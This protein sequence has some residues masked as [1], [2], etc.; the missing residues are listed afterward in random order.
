MKITPRTSFT[1]NIKCQVDGFEGFL[2]ACEFSYS[3]LSGVLA[4][5]SSSYLTLNNVCN[6]SERRAERCDFYFLGIQ[7]VGGPAVYR[8]LTRHDGQDC[9]VCLESTGCFLTLRP[10]AGH[11][12]TYW[13]IRFNGVMNDPT[14]PGKYPGMTL[15]RYSGDEDPLFYEEPGNVDPGAVSSEDFITPR[16]RYEAG[17][18]WN[19]FLKADGRA[20]DP[21]FVADLYVKRVDKEP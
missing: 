19:A 1:A 14:E 3:S 13:H 20:C 18:Y 9:E 16:A 5:R 12:P 4:S 6:G 11:A 21:V 2:D 7:L 8:I 17:A 10:C 15:Q